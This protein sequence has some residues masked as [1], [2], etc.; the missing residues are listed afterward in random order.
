MFYFL[1][2]VM[3]YERPTEQTWLLDWMCPVGI[4]VSHLSKTPTVSNGVRR[5]SVI[6]FSVVEKYYYL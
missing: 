4:G 3:Y 6:S 1:N 5:N 2:V